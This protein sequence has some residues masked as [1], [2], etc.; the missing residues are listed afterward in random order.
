MN[1]IDLKKAKDEAISKAIKDHKVFFA[2]SNEQFEK[3]KTELQP[4]EKYVRLQ[5]DGFIPELQFN[6]FIKEMVKVQDNF[7]KA[8]EE[9][10]LKEKHIIYELQNYECFYTMDP[11]E[12]INALSDFY[13]EKEILEVFSKCVKSGEYND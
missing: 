4:N 2:F 3:S 8:V 1:L 5:D 10:N 12:A 6:S 13:S 7:K 9:N 11:T